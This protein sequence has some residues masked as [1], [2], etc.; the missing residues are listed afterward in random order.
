MF[1]NSYYCSKGDCSGVTNNESIMKENDKTTTE[2]M[3]SIL[4]I[5][6]ACYTVLITTGKDLWVETFCNSFLK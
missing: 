4:T 5:S 6:W 3:V 2:G 1:N